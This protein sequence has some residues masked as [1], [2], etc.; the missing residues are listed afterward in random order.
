VLV[1]SNENIVSSIDGINFTNT[2]RFDNLSDGDYTLLIKNENGCLSGE[3]FTILKIEKPNIILEMQNACENENN[4]SLKLSG[5]GLDHTV[6]FNNFIISKDTIIENLSPQQYKVFI[7]DKHCLFEFDATINSVPL[8]QFNLDAH[9]SCPDLP[10]GKIFI[11]STENLDFT[12]DNKPVMNVI[13]KLKEGIYKIFG[14]NKDGCVFEKE[15]KIEKLQEL[16]VEFPEITGA[17]LFV[18]DTLMPRVRNFAG[19]LQYEW[20]DATKD[21]LYI[22]K[23]NGISNVSVSIKDECK[24]IRRSW[25]IE[26]VNEDIDKIIFVPNIFA[27]GVQSP[28]NCFKGTYAQN[29]EKVIHYKLH[30]YDRWGSLMYTTANN[31]DCWDGSFNGRTCEEGVYVYI[32]DTTVSVCGKIKSTRIVKDITLIK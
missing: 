3:N 16:I 6:V 20:H 31:E 8:P 27:R 5:L 4:G 13:D 9:P 19:S 15:I 18:G 24:S 28:N 23:D 2:N 32:L 29:V 12:F 10:N 21:S 7:K 14:K 11:S 1:T 26:A 30:I 22:L 25:Q 17:C